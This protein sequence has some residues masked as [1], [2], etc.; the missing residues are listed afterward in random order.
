MRVGRASPYG[1]VWVRV[2]GRRRV[3]VSVVKEE[4]KQVGAPA[5]GGEEDHHLQDLCPRRLRAL[6][7]QQ[8]RGLDDL[9]M[10][11]GNGGAKGSKPGVSIAATSE[12]WR[13]GR[14]DCEIVTFR[15]GDKRRQ[16]GKHT[17]FGQRLDNAAAVHAAAS[18]HTLHC[19]SSG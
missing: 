18:I 16:G 12:K 17:A 5:H 8:V 7:P 11:R 10:L 15:E 4:Q 2:L 3:V 14:A 1:G 13:R 9:P 19:S 6:L